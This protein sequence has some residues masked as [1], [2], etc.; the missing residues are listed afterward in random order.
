GALGGRGVHQPGRRAREKTAQARLIREIYSRPARVLVCL[1]EDG[2]G[3]LQREGKPSFLEHNWRPLAHVLCRPG[4][5][6]RWVIQEVA[7][8]DDG[9]PRL[10]I[11]G[12]I[13]FAWED[14]AR[15]AYRLGVYGI[16]TI[17]SAQS[18]SMSY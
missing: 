6:L 16:T 14:L 12:D 15:V 11:C 3:Q 2:G 5:G 1:G 17:L 13:D 9:V 8:A 4:F 10:A 7:L 18:P